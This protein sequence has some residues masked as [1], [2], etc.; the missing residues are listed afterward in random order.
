MLDYDSIPHIHEI[1]ALH[2]QFQDPGV[3]TRT[4]TFVE[5]MHSHNKIRPSLEDAIERSGLRDGM[6]ISRKVSKFHA[7]GRLLCSFPRVK[8]RLFGFMGPNSL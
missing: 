3:K 8:K 5:R 6:T 2:G 7:R 1:Q 4:D